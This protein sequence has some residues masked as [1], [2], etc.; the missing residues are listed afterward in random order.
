MTTSSSVCWQDFFSR[1]PCEYG[2]AR[3]AEAVEKHGLHAAVKGA[4]DSDRRWGAEAT[5]RVDIL[6]IL[7]QDTNGDVRCWVASNPNTPAEVLATLAQDADD[8]VCSIAQQRIT[9]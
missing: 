9:K 4:P 2:F 1:K 3:F 5:Y 8:D 6:A 7:A